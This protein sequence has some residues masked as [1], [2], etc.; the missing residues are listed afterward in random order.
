MADK[1]WKAAERRASALFSARRNR[2]SGSSN[3]DD[4]SRSDS[5]HERLFI[6]TK[7]Y[8]SMAVI[9]LYDETRAHAKRE[10][11]TPVLMLAKKHRKGFIIACDVRDLAKVAAELAEVAEAMADAPPDDLASI[12]PPALPFGTVEGDDSPPPSSAA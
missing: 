10:K 2:L 7:V 11:K 9:S 6:E 12:E 3:R 1:H 8:S 4:Q 5:T